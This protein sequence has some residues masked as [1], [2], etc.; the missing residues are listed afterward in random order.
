ML[1]AGVRRRAGLSGTHWPLGGPE[2]GSREGTRGEPSGSPDLCVLRPHLS[3][4]PVSTYSAWAGT[5]HAMALLTHRV[6]LHFR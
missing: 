3:S 2:S 1:G 5:V 4:S 6:G